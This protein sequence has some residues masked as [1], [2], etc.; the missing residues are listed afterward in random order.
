M[1]WYYWLAIAI[2]I[3][4]A[5]IRALEGFPDAGFFRRLVENSRTMPQKGDCYG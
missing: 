3:I 2:I 1:P 4:A 5:P